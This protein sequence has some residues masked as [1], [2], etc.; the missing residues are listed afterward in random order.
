MIAI[1]MGVHLK[2]TEV[3]SAEGRSGDSGW[4]SGNYL[5]E[6]LKGDELFNEVRIFF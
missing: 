1:L 5:R 4:S 3:K 6:R 2:E